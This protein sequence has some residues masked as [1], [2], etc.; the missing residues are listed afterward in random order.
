MFRLHSTK[1]MKN[2]N[3]FCMPRLIISSPD[4]AH[5]LPFIVEIHNILFD[6]QSCPWPC[7]SSHALLV[8]PDGCYLPNTA[9]GLFQLQARYSRRRVTAAST[10]RFSCRRVIN[11]CKRVAASGALLTQATGEWSISIC[12]LDRREHLYMWPGQKRASLYVTWTEGSISICDLD[13]RSISICDLDRREHLYMR[14]GQKGA[15][16]YVTWTEGNISICDLDR[17]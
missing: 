13:R 17:K 14:P 8:E 10:L 16:L 1:V 4:R 5:V 6:T 7:H 12:D 9:I 15:S 11:S 2:C 3:E